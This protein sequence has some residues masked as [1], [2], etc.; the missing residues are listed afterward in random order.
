M[1]TMSD[2]AREAGVSKTTVSYVSSGNPSIS[3]G[4]RRKVL[5][6]MRK[7][8]YSVNRTARAL[9]T[10]KTSTIGIFAP[11]HQDYQLSLSM[12]A[13]LYGLAEAARGYG[14]DAMLLTDPDGVG[15]IRR[16]S[17][18]HALDGAVILDVRNGDERIEAARHAKLPT[19][20]LGSPS[21]PA[22]LD[23][24]DT[25]FEQA[26]RDLVEELSA[27][28]YRDVIF[29]GLPRS[30]YAHGLNYAIRFR[31]TFLS[32]CRAAGIAVHEIYAKETMFGASEV[33]RRA[34]RQYPGSS[35]MVIHNDGVVIGAAQAFEQLGIRVPDKM[36]VASLV[37]DQLEEGMGFPFDTVRI[38]VP[39]VASTT[40]DVLMDRI[41][42]PHSP[43]RKV[44]LHQP[45][46]GAG[47]SV[48][49]AH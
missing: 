49:S 16:A 31:A 32:E 15:A 21:D 42:H 6:A 38:D 43:A 34:V 1:V 19:V 2:V 25:D 8:G 48:A 3:E 26:A 28:G 14:Y 33:I 18:G 9:S 5:A 12:G 41:A 27:R 7:L 39:A 13:Y 30:V 17:D 35:A 45:L 47:Q 46:V 37:P 4:T 11:I 40:I 44:L 23:V 20:L 10:S 24:I 36:Y 22:G 29:I